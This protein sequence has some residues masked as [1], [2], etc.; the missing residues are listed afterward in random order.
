[1]ERV[2]LVQQEP[3]VPSQLIEIPVTT[4]GITRIQLPDVQQLRSTTDRKIILKKLRLI[5]HK[6][7]SHAPL[8]GQ[9]TA[10]LTELVKMTLVLYSNG[11]EKGQQIPVLFLNPMR[12]GDST[13]A[14]TIPSSNDAATSFDNW[15]DV[16]WAKSY[17]LYSNG[18]GGAAGQPYSIMFEAQYIKLNSGG[19][20]IKGT[21]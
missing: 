6:I 7:L 2:M 19:E 9:A 18:T 14:T 13:T 10:P 1:M 3:R 11:W 20:E 4:N 15:E 8:G 21:K 17:I 5:T 12:D 16:D